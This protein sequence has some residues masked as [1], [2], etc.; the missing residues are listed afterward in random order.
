[1][2]KDGCVKVTINCIL[3]AHTP[4]P[5][6]LTGTE[7]DMI[8]HSFAEAEIGGRGVELGSAATS[9]T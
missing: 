3:D 6:R 5:H 4:S 2:G 7:R 9:L 8:G 1:M